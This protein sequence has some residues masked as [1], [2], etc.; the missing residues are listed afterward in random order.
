M[1]LNL[2]K[3]DQT[4]VS[5]ETPLANAGTMIGAVFEFEGVEFVV[6]SRPS[7]ATEITALQ[8][9]PMALDSSNFTLI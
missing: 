5:G 1:K 8:V 4:I 7:Y 3:A 6:V 9:M 2:H